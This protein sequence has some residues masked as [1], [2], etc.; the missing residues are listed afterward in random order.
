MGDSEFIC[1]EVLWAEEISKNLNTKV[2][3]FVFSHSPQYSNPFLQATHGSDVAF[4]LHNVPST[5]V[6]YTNEDLTIS[7]IM[8]DLWGQYI[9]GNFTNLS[10]FNASTNFSLINIT[11]TTSTSSITSFP[12]IT[13]WKHD[14]CNKLWLPPYESSFDEIVINDTVKTYPTINLTIPELGDLQGIDGDGY[15][16]YLKIPYAEPPLQNLRWS[17]P[18]SPVKWTGIYDSTNFP[19]PCPQIISN[20]FPLDTNYDEDCLYLSLWR[21]KNQ[22]FVNGN[23]V[24]VW[25]HGGGLLFGGIKI[26][27]YN[28]EYMAR[29]ESIVFISIQYRIGLLGFLG[30]P[31]LKQ[32]D[33]YKTTG[34]YGIL[35]QNAA[36]QWV[37]KYIKAF[38]GDPNKITIDGESAGA[39]SVFFH[40]TIPQSQ[41]LYNQAI[42]QSNAAFV[43]IQSP[44]V[45]YKLSRG[46]IGNVCNLSSNASILL[47][48]MRKINIHTLLSFYGDDVSEAMI[49]GYLFTEHPYNFYMNW[50]SRKHNVSAVLIG[51]T[52]NE[53]SIF[54]PRNISSNN[55]SQYLYFKFPWIQ[56][57]DIEYLK[58]IYP[59]N[60]SDCSS[61]LSDFLGDSWFYCPD[62]LSAQEMSI[63]QNT[64][65]FSYVFSHAPKATK[66]STFDGAYHSSE[67]AYAFNNVPSSYD[68]YTNEELALSNAMAKTWAKFIK[69]DYSDFPR[70]SSESNYSRVNFSVPVND[71]YPVI[72]DWKQDLCNDVWLPIMNKFD[73]KLVYNETQENGLNGTVK[74]IIPSV[75]ELIGLNSSNYEA[76][77]KIAYAKSPL[78]NM[79]FMPPEP[80]DAW[81]GSYDSTVYPPACPQPLTKL[82]W[83]DNVTF[84]EDCLFLSIWKP[85]NISNA[86]VIVWF[87]GTY[88]IGG[89]QLKSHMGQYMAEQES[90]VFVIVQYRIG[91]LGFMG[92]PEL[93]TNNSLNTTGNY[94]LLHQIQALK[95]VQKNIGAFGGDQN[96]VTIGG[97]AEGAASICLHMIISQS[98][99]LFSQSMLHSFDCFN[100]IIPQQV[101]YKKYR[102]I[103]AL[104]C[105]LTLN[106]SSILNCLR[107]LD[108][109]VIV[110]A[111][112][113][114]L[115]PMIDNYLLKEHPY[116]TYRNLSS[117]NTQLNVSAILLGNNAN[118]GSIFITT[119]NI[120]LFN[121]YTAAK[122]YN[123]WI[124]SFDLLNTLTY[125]PCLA[126]D[127]KDILSELIS[128]GNF[129][130]PATL[131]SQWISNYTVKPKIFDFI[132]SHPTDML[133]VTNPSYG[134]FYTSD[135]PYVWHNI[136]TTYD[137]CT[138]DELELSNNMAKTWANFIKGN[139]SDLREYN[140]Q[141]N[142]QK[143]NFTTQ[144]PSPP[145]NVTVEN[146]KKQ[147]CEEA[148]LNAYQNAFGYLVNND[149]NG[150]NEASSAEGLTFLSILVIMMI[151]WMSFIN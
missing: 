98:Q 112:I 38:G 63:D 77:L 6:N 124:N 122:Q 33:P 73:R 78:K 32:E 116:I 67:I 21:P 27:A 82:T 11:T 123:E 64:K 28:G 31:E 134:A 60:I 48:C 14:L 69:G 143:I 62:I 90:I 99:G 53:G 119:P 118:E 20:D 54:I 12:I 71:I 125:Y 132:F 97:F 7:D 26:N 40:L 110:N 51:N 76:Y 146:W 127:C 84:D 46:I 4:A 108:V 101:G 137:Y 83:M 56:D 92:L 114:D 150:T 59:C 34:N 79:R 41:G 135:I 45:K 147:L 131:I 55:Y 121:Y 10:E 22:S 1:N 111:P 47:S 42:V 93:K 66:F 72:N 126:L 30:L 17:N 81:N 144:Y 15:E 2:F 103:M 115:G 65:V 96:K 105:N 49:D 39:S 151:I 74:L 3:T 75:G 142:H 104:Q 18:I 138:V 68:F 128:D 87:A 109:N 139:Y 9:K 133:S 136:L 5:F 130:C 85:K 113:D 80:L 120:P 61:V 24:V 129:I 50:A 23:P 140:L 13:N 148:W 88:V 16:A 89:A 44:T 37:K 29:N 149:T 94:G 52:L 107:S 141:Y 106:E 86:S 19:N 8:A 57:D 91:L 95:W 70:Y 36:L 145:Y 100:H 117:R 102:E 43:E 25:I 58:G 35:D